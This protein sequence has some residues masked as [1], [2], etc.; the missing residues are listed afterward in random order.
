MAVKWAITEES[1]YYV[2]LFAYGVFLTL[3]D[4]DAIE[5][6]G[7]TFVAYRAEE[8]EFFS[9]RAKWKTIYITCRKTPAFDRS[10][11]DVIAD[12]QK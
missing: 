10:A 12:P 7:L 6:A 11:F 1:K 2:R 9:S 5:D 4:R 8:E 3:S